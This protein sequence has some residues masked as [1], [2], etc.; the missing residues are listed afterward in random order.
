[1]W[2]NGKNIGE[3]ILMKTQKVARGILGVGG[4][5][6]EVKLHLCASKTLKTKAFILKTNK[7]NFWT[8]IGLLRKFFCSSVRLIR[9]SEKLSRI[10]A[11]IFWFG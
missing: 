9:L 7:L 8:W 5:V 1:M 11:S 3:A 10:I 4:N 6:F 2:K